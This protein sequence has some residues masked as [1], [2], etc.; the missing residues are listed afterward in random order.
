MQ[1]SD[2]VGQ[3]SAKNHLL[4]MWQQ[5][6]L[7]H[8]LL[9]CGQEGTGGLP[10]AFALAQY[11]LCS[12][13][14]DTDSCGICPNCQKIAKLEH[15]DVHLSF[16]SIKPNSNSKVL[17]SNYF[18]EF[19]AYAL[20]NPYGTAFDWLQ[21][22]NAENKQGNISADECRA[23]IESLSLKSYEGGKKILIMWRPEFLGKEGNILLKLIEEPPSD[24]LIILVAEST[25]EILP[26]ILSRIQ[27]I[28]LPPIKAAEIAE[29]LIKQYDCEA[30]RA[31][32]MARLAEGSFTTALQLLQEEDNDLFPHARNLFNLLFTHN[33]IGLS[34]FSEDMAKLGREQQKNFLHYLI[35]LLETTLKQRFTG[36]CNLANEELVFV[37][38]LSATQLSFE[39]ISQ[40]IDDIA[41]TSYHIQR[42]SSSKMQ[43][44]ALCIK[45]M[46]AIQNKKVSSLVQ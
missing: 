19:R 29:S 40:I 37:Q 45:M 38:K 8:A 35:H 23:I 12:N 10:L 27:A 43:L 31:N 18:K 6:H 22:I 11:L 7:P 44:H 2:I 30:R 32:Q 3:S 5:N 13:K 46:Y 33:G 14:S 24:T 21:Y 41:K 28:K 42:N 1:F 9:I 15:A 36:Q 26:T 39:T 20:A 16:P 17:S 34:K 25:E 4:G